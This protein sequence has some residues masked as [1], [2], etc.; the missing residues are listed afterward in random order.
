[1][2]SLSRTGRVAVTLLTMEKRRTTR[3][4][5]LPFLRRRFPDLPDEELK[6]AEERYI[7]YLEILLSI[8]EYDTRP[9]PD[10]TNEGK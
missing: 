4:F 3:H 5:P 2:V 9:H 7:R 6:E 10:S 1:M 8:Y